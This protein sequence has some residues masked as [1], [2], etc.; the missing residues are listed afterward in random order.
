MEKVSK[1]NLVVIGLMLMMMAAIIVIMG[2]N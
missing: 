1:R 2:M